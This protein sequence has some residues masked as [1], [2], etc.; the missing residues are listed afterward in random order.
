M[1]WAKCIT[2]GIGHCIPQVVKPSAHSPPSSADVT[3]VWRFTNPDVALI[4]TTTLLQNV[5]VDIRSTATFGTDDKTALGTSAD[6]ELHPENS[7]LGS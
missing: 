7:F 5:L 2:N 4:H 6:N 3:N 1:N